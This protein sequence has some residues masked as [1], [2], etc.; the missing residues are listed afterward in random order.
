MEQSLEKSPAKFSPRPRNNKN[1]ILASN[2]A[3]T[4]EQFVVLIEDV[5]KILNAD[6]LMVK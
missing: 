1:L 5:V 6:I 2:H 4:I 3:E